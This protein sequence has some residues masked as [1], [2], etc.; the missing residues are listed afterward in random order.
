MREWVRNVY[1]V[2]GSCNFE[3]N[4]RNAKK[5]EMYFI[6]KTWRFFIC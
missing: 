6:Q 2:G 4:N 5:T 1:F 3:V